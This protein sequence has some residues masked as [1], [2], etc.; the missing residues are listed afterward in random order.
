MVER[1]SGHITT[2]HLP[3]FDAEVSSVVWFRDYAAYCG[4]TTA[5][6]SK[7]VAVVA[8]A[9]RTK[10]VAERVI[11][12]W[13]QAPPPRPACGAS[14][15]QRGPVRVTLTPAGAPPITFEVTGTSSL[16]EESDSPERE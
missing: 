1:S 13:P 12:K 6:S 3:A 4:I 11:G 16:M 2:L 15:W 7:L 14:L 10:A 5:A 8:Q 9:G